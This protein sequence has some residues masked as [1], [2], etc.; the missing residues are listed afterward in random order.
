MLVTDCEMTGLEPT[1]HS[2]VSVGA[3][4]F[5]HPERQ[6][7]EEC[8]AWDGASIEDEALAV[9]GFT[10]EQI[11]DTSKQTEG[12]L[13]HKFISF[14]E[15]MTDTTIAGQNVFTDL[16][17]L[18]AAAKRAGH[19]AWP[20]AHRIIDIHSLAWEHMVKRGL[21][22]PLDPEKRHSKLNLDAALTYCGI[23]EEPKPHNALTGAKCSAEVIS[24]LLYDKKLLPEFEQ[25]DIPWLK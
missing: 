3:V 2:I 25:F 13:V 18:Q 6:L 7:Y 22:P 8:C 11:T 24:R 19:T 15:G 5:D 17:F 12:E 4:D 9:N 14:A 21:T 20:F 23:P 1:L 16:Y 10:R